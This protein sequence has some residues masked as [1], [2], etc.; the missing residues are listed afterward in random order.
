MA[1][2]DTETRSTEHLLSVCFE[3]L[4]GL[5]GARGSTGWKMSPCEYDHECT[6]AKTGATCGTRCLP[7][8]PVAHTPTQCPQSVTVTA[9]AF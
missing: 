1:S 9:P 7:D 2:S 8:P 6:A 3:V 4:A 5:Q